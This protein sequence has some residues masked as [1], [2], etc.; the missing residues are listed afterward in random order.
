MNILRELEQKPRKRPRRNQQPKYRVFLGG[1]STREDF[2]AIQ[3]YFSERGIIESCKVKINK[4][5]GRCIGY[6][7][8]TCGDKATF[9]MILNEKHVVNGRAV[10]SKPL[11][12]K[13]K[14]AEMVEDERNRKVF[15]G[16]L[17]KEITGEDMKAEFSKYGA[18]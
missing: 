13:N 16:N 6:G 1:I 18:I 4:K 2:D 14:L 8:L 5:T 9:D 12:K 17:Q 15:V 11:L 7:Y 3:K 10:D